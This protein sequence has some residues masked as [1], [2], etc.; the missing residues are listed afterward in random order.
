MKIFGQIISVQALAL[1]VSLP[2]QLVGHVPI[3]QISSHYT[4]LL[5]ALTE[6]GEKDDRSDVN[7]EDTNEEEEE[8]EDGVPHLGEMFQPGQYVRAVVTA[9]RAAGTREGLSSKLGLGS[10]TSFG[11]DDLERTSRRVELSLDPV[12]VNA[13]LSKADVCFGLVSCIVAKNNSRFSH[14]RVWGG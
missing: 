14:L 8:E 5:N 4:S 12:Q 11:L 7:N 3:T 9:V 2:N 13:G 10:G 6:S 1:I